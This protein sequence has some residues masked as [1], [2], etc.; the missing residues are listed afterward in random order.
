M[1]KTS[2]ANAFPA[3]ISVSP[4]RNYLNFPFTEEKR[5]VFNCCGKNRATVTFWVQTKNFCRPSLKTFAIQKKAIFSLVSLKVG[6]WT[7]NS[8]QM[9]AIS[10]GTNHNKQDLFLPRKKKFFSWLR[11][12]VE[13]FFLWLD[14]K[15]Q[16][17]K[18]EVII[19]SFQYW[20]FCLCRCQPLAPQ[21]HPYIQRS[22]NL[23][24]VI[25]SNSGFPSSLIS[26]L[27]LQQ[28]SHL[29]EVL[30]LTQLS[31]FFSQQ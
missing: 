12:F 21:Q 18:K 15:K 25:F 1:Q 16:D 30:G 17:R 20:L 29:F 10:S 13:P 11:P 26:Y 2:S 22:H 5:T 28:L 24:V 14:M 4:F 23:Q 6:Q 31:V 7:T 9:R 8:C 19:P 3:F 27:T